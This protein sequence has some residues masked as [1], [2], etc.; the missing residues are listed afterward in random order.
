MGPSRREE[1]FVN[2]LSN[3]GG[4][5]GLHN[6]TVILLIIKKGGVLFGVKSAV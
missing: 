4:M 1:F 2:V 5:G 6:N 3:T